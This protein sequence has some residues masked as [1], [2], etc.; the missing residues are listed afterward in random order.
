MIR[1]RYALEKYFSQSFIV[2]T[3]T[4]DGCSFVSLLTCVRA[5]NTAAYAATHS[6]PDS[7]AYA[8]AYCSAKSTADATTYSAADGSTNPTAYATTHRCAFIINS[9]Q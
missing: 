2:E 5:T 8:T 9:S 7:V 3:M 1:K 4:R 6:A